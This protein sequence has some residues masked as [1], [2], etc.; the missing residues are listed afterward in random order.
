LRSGKAL[1]VVR[2]IGRGSTVFLLVEETS[3]SHGDVTCEVARIS[4]YNETLIVER[5]G[6]ITV[7]V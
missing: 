4:V 1:R 7:L 3:A 2:F 6:A 5:E